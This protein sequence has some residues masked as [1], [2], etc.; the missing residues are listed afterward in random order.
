MRNHHDLVGQAWEDESG[1]GGSI[2]KEKE[3]QARE[4]ARQKALE[5]RQKALEEEGRRKSK[6]QKRDKGRSS[7]K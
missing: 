4:E 1:G 5:V 6:N 3:Q 7:G 2:Q